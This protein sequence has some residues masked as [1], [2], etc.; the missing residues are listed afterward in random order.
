VGT[1]AALFLAIVPATIDEIFDHG[2]L[3]AY[4]PE[5]AVLTATLIALIW[6]AY[7][8]FQLVHQ[9]RLQATQD[10][11]RRTETAKALRSAIVAELEEFQLELERS[12]A[13]RIPDDPT[14]FPR[15]QLAR[16][17]AHPEL[18]RPTDMAVLTK[19]DFLLRRQLSAGKLLRKTLR[20]TK[21]KR[22]KALRDP[23]AAPTINEEAKEFDRRTYEFVSQS[24]EKLAS[25]VKLALEILKEM[26]LFSIRDD[27]KARPTTAA[28]T[29][30]DKGK[31]SPDPATDVTSP[32]K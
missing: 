18:F 19:L 20:K 16:A 27:V 11:R 4:D 10:R 28:Q 29:L 5:I 23:A 17:L 24:R 21:Q 13:L 1:G 15:D 9:A 2:R 14:T 32:S 25:I 22:R 26:N 6:T 3:P 30:P 8:T 7:H 12:K 31:R